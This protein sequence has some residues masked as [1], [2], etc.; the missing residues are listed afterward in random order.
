LTFIRLVTYT[1]VLPMA[2]D[3]YPDHQIDVELSD[4]DNHW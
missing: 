3:L 1:H 4:E 2:Q